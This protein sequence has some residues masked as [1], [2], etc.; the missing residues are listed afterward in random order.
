MQI[1]NISLIILCSG[2]MSLA[3]LAQQGKVCAGNLGWRMGGMAAV[4]HLVLIVLPSVLV[5]P[6]LP[7]RPALPHFSPP[8]FSYSMTLSHHE[9]CPT[10]NAGPP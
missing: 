3:V 7:I 4:L 9:C 6:D 2:V 8:H 5:L 10:L 1:R